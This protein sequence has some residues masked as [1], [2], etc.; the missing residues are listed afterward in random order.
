M[1][2]LRTTR[3]I[4]GWL[5]S[6][7]GENNKWTASS[8]KRAVSGKKKYTMGI[9]ARLMAVKDDVGLVADIGDHKRS[10]LDDKECGEPLDDDG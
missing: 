10:D 4:P 2:L 8:G 9:A 3:K 1:V 5:P 7:I 6:S